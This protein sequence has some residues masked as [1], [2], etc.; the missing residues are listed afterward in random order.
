MQDKDRGL[1]RIPRNRGILGQE[2]FF[3]KNKD[4][5]WCLRIKEGKLWGKMSLDLGENW[6]DWQV[7]LTDY[8][9]YFSFNFNGQ[10]ALH[11]LCKKTTGEIAY[12]L[13]QGQEFTVNILKDGYLDQEQVTYQ[14]ILIDEEDRV[15]LL[16]FTENKREKIWK[17]KYTIRENQEWSKPVVLDYGVGPGLEQGTAAFDLDGTLYLIYQIYQEGI[18]QFVIREKKPNSIFWE[19]KSIITG[20]KRSNL[21]PCL[22]IDEK[23]TLHLVWVR[24]DGMNYRVI[25]RQKTRGGWMV[26]GWQEDRELSL[27]GYNCYSPTIGILDKKVV[28]IWQQ[29]DGIYKAV[30]LDEGRTFAKPELQERYQG[31]L[32]KN[33]ITLDAYKTQGLNTM[34]TFDTGSTSVALLATVFQEEEGSEEEVL[35]NLP[36][37]KE[38]N[39]PSIDFG[40]KGLEEQL[41]KINGNFKKMYFETEDVRLT[42]LQMKETLEEKNKEI[43]ILTHKVSQKTQEI[44]KI[45]KEQRVSEQILE[46]LKENI[47]KNNKEYEEN[48]NSKKNRIKVLDGEK[49]N[50]QE[51]LVKANE[52]I[53]ELR[54]KL[55]KKEEII[56]NNSIREENLKKELKNVQGE[57]EKYIKQPFW[58]KIF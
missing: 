41:Q 12:I 55:E 1:L 17:I 21:N 4:Y 57:L 56:K 16:Y 10:D 9:G 13:W 20:S 52:I 29:V 44:E 49:K 34:A 58:R 14:N 11:L 25:Y 43:E 40:Q 46:K 7:L 27:P 45:S 30:S 51:K 42:N 24:S 50:L 22:V 33:I 48:L 39:Y 38:S 23:G 19:D 53:I 32:Y 2:I 18:Y 54:E 6:L 35:L 15:H 37:L 3:I 8:D 26:G 5:L 36:E 28:V 47:L 31:L